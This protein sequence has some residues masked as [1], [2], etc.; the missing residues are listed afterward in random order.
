MDEAMVTSSILVCWVNESDFTR[1]RPSV[2]VRLHIRK[3][4]VDKGP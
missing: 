1:S 4:F 2:L 3:F